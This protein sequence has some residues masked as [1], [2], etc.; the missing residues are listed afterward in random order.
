MTCCR[1]DPVIKSISDDDVQ[2]LSRNKTIATVLPGTSFFLNMPYAPA[3]R[4]IGAGCAVAV[5]VGFLVYC[6]KWK[7][8]R[9]KWN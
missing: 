8:K 9:N 1:I 5:A 7:I 4:L 6:V 3:R 2:L